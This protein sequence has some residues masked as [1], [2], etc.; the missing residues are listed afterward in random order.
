MKK[1]KSLIEMEF[2]TKLCIMKKHFKKIY[3]DF[4]P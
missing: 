1:R 2:F 3:L 4:T